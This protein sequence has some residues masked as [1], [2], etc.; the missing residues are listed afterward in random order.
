MSS[1]LYRIGRACY[2]HGVRVLIVWLALVAALGGTVDCS[3]VPSSTTAS[4]SPG[5]PRRSPST[6]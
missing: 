4:G 1:M 3:A 5:H 2:R 6:S